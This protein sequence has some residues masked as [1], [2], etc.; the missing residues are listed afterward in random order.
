MSIASFHRQV[1]DNNSQASL[2][3]LSVL[4]SPEQLRRVLEAKGRFWG[5]IIW[6]AA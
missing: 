4:R 3:T 6:P 1:R 2:E 5:W